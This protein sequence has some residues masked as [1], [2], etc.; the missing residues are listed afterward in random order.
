MKLKSCC[1]DFFICINEKELDGDSS[2]E[3]IIYEK[4]L[5]IYAGLIQETT[6]ASAESNSGLCLTP[7]H[8][9]YMYIICILYVYVY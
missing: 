5:C 7:L 8:M 1:W 6:S 9:Q 4:V 3:G 2:S